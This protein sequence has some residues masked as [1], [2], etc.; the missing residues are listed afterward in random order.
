M[1]KRHCPTP[2]PWRLWYGRAGAG[3][4]AAARA[5]R[6]EVAAAL[7]L[8]HPPASAAAPEALPG[9]GAL[10]AAPLHP[11]GLHGVRRLGVARRGTPGWG[12]RAARGAAA[13]QALVG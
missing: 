12:G 13:A 7:P 1:K 5:D 9:R 10:R 3:P 4:A 8:P 2:A 6:S 11:G